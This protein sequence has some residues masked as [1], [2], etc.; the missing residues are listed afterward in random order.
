MFAEVG[1]D[2]L[3]TKRNLITSYLEFI[4]HEID[5]ELE[6]ADFEILTP[7]K[8]RRTIGCQLSVYLHEAR[9]R[10]IR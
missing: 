5:K 1:M 4:L 6:G 10:T 2:K 3:I 7:S 9:K 8:S